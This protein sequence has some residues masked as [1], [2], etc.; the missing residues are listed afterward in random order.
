[1]NIQDWFPL[2]LTGL[3]CLQSKG[4]SRVFSST[5]VQKHQFFGTQPSL[6]SNSHIRAWLLRKTIVLTIQTCKEIKPVNP[7][8]NLSWIFFGRADGEAETPILWPPDAKNWFIGKDPVSSGSWW[9]TGKPG[10][11]QSMGSQRVRHD[12]ATEMSWTKLIRTFVRKVMALCFSTLSR[13]VIDLLPRSKHLLISWLQSSS[14]VIL[15]LKKI[16]SVTLS[17]VSLSICPEMIGTGCHD[18][19][20]F[21]VEF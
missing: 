8:G 11:L 15:E 12:W 14:A 7:K 4:L 18:L 1:M 21:N 13:F 17:V 2:G 9:C 10:V 6:G 19:S 3:V 16:K 5:T 20:F